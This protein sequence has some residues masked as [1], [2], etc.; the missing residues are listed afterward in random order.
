M[1][2]WRHAAQV[3]VRDRFIWR[4]HRKV[5]ARTKGFIYM[6]NL[7][8]LTISV[9]TFAAGSSSAQT[10]TPT[11][12]PVATPAPTVAPVATPTPIATPQVQ[13]S[14]ENVPVPAVAPTFESKIGTLP[15]VTRVGVD[16]QNQL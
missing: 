1:A 5:T 8:L 7:F 9:L 3:C 11:P 6:R 13:A 14:P 4:S 10:A 16:M 2:I 15:E 12:M